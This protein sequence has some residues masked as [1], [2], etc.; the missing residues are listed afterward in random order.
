V[1][2]L[3]DAAPLFVNCLR[4]RA[5]LLFGCDVL[6][7]HNHVTGVRPHF[8]LRGGDDAHRKDGP[9]SAPVGCFDGHR[10]PGTHAFG[11]AFNLRARLRGGKGFRR[12]SGQLF[13]R[14]AVHS[15]GPAVGGQDDGWRGT[16]IH[17]EDTQRNILEKVAKALFI[18]TGQVLRSLEGA[19]QIRMIGGPVAVCVG[20]WLGGI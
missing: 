18:L 7:S 16:Q 4:L 8:Y 3:G 11:Q 9:I 19:G 1:D 2:L 14:P 12:H 13:G 6:H 15:L 17:L 10:L 20:S 5:A